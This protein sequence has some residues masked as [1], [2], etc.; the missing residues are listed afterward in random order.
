MLSKQQRQR[1]LYNRYKLL[2]LNM[3]KWEGLPPTVKPR[4]IEK[5]LY[6]KGMCL[7]FEHKDIGV[8]CLPCCYSKNFNV[9]GEGTSYIVSG[10]GYSTTKDITDNVELGLNN[11]LGECTR[12]YV[13]SYAE[14]MAD[15]EFS[16]DLNIRK[17]RIPWIV[18]TT[19]ENKYSMQKA[20][21]E[22]MEGKEVVYANKDLGLNNSNV[23][24]LT[25]PFIALQLNE[26]KYELER[27]ILTFFGLNNTVEKNER[28]IVDEVNSN[29]DF[30]EQNVEIMFR[31]RQDLCERINKRYGW[32]VSVKKTSEIVSCETLKEGDDNE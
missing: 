20:M 4:H 22:I 11:D 31:N 10:F 7:F 14:R 29:N 18:E 32:N 19:R 27:E 2:A 17:Q 16:I 6:E 24:T 30:I 15:I 13:R 3:F 23:I 12:Q 28:L 9:Y 25:A 5:A 1:L 8:I 21:N 26:Y